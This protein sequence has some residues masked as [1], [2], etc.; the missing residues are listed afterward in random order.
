MH[1]FCQ[2]HSI[3]DQPKDMYRKSLPEARIWTL[4][5]RL[6]PLPITDHAMSLMKRSKKKDDDTMSI[7]LERTDDIL[8]YLGEHKKPVSSYAAFSMETQNMLDELQEKNWKR[9]IWI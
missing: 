4:S 3:V 5:S 1:R 2:Y 6:L 7:P 8:K 9:R